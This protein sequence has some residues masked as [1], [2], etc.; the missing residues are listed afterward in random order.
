MQVELPEK[1]VELLFTPARYKIAYGGRGSAKSWGFAD[2]LIIE[3]ISGKKLILCTRE[4]QK[5]I[6]ESVHRLLGDRIVAMGLESR[7]E[8]QQTRIIERVTGSEFLFAGLRHNISN[9]KSYEGVDR[10]WVEE[11]QAVSDSSWNVLIPTIRKEG[12]EIWVSYNPDLEDDPTHQRFVMN[13]PGNSRSVKMTWRDNPWFPEVLKQEMEDLKAR[14]YK[15]YLNVW[16]GE[17]R[18]AV[19]GAIFADE[20]QKAA[21]ENRITRVAPEGGRPVMTFW[22]LG[23]SD[24]TAIWFVQIVGMEYRLIDYYQANGRKMGHYIDELAKRGYLYG[25]HYLPHDATHEQLAAQSTI[26]SQLKTAIKDNP[27]LGEGVKVIPRIP[28]KGLAIDAARG[29]F[30]RCV[31]DKEKT[32]DGLQC[33]RH[34]RYATDPETGKIGKEPMHDIWSHGADAFLA[35]GQHAKPT[36]PDKPIRPNTAWVR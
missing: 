10:V 24:Y 9:L 23:E 8:I 32:A 1:L 4:I 2:A 20:L 33:L 21:E 19:E 18:Q 12:S 17:C 28:K 34:F 5:S 29:I 3:A 35:V 26:E 6:Q 25:Y 27:R 16:E 7:F 11:A 30:D 13:K 22:D 36:A 15:A 14:D 31:F